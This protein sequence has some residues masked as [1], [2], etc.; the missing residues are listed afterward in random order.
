MMTDL[1]DSG[2]EAL[3]QA[4][5]ARTSGG[6]C[7]AARERLCDFVDDALA[8]FDRDL[9]DGHLAHCPNCA[10]LAAALAET[11]GVLPSFALLPPRAGIVGNVLSATSRRP[12]APTLGERVSAW[13][14]RAAARPRFSL[15]VA[16]VLT[17]L[18]LV[19]LGNPVAA[20]RDASARVQPRMAVVADA[21]RRPIA[22]M[23]TAGEGALTSVERA[24][25]PKT[26]P[27]DALSQGRALLSQFWQT[28]VDTPVRAIVLQVGDWARRVV[29]ELRTIVGAPASEPPAGHVR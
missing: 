15:E 19:V 23:R 14:A 28:Y 13:L 24:V 8:P 29:N 10:G 22:Q 4:I 11:A 27:R 3:T 17:V 25:T 1:D 26:E 5:L 21:V 16:Y 2:H 7:A 9:T 6:G 12:P 18:L 20:F